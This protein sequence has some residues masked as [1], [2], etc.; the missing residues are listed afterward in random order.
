MG[1]YHDI[2]STPSCVVEGCMLLPVMNSF[3]EDEIC[4]LAEFEEKMQQA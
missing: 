2:T 3:P 1:P 4:C